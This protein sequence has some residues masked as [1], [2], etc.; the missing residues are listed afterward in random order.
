MLTTRSSSRDRHQTRLSDAGFFIFDRDSK[1]CLKFLG[2][3]DVIALDFA[4]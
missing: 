2:L 1:S 4:P 3:A